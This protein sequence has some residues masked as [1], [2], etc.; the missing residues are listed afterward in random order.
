MLMSVHVQQSHR[1]SVAKSTVERFSVWVEKVLNVCETLDLKLL[2]FLLDHLPEQ[3]DMTWHQ[4][5]VTDPLGKTE[6]IIRMVKNTYTKQNE[7]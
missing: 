1:S 6:V 3:H 2:W 4:T 7:W 5:H